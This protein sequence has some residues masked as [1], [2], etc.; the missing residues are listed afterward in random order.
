VLPEAAGLLVVILLS[1]T[2][3]DHNIAMPG[4]TAAISIRLLDQSVLHQGH[5][6]SCVQK[7]KWKLVLT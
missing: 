2:A 4:H 7:Y 5:L 6:G 1:P 3:R